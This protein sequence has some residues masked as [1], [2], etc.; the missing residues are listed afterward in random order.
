MARASSPEYSRFASPARALP[1]PR[2]LGL[3]FSAGSDSIAVSATPVG[4]GGTTQQPQ[5]RFLSPASPT[6]VTSPARVM[7]PSRPTPRLSVSPSR[8]TSPRLSASMTVPSSSLGSIA[9]QAGPPSTSQT[10]ENRPKAAVRGRPSSRLQGSA[11]NYSSRKSYDHKAAPS[12]AQASRMPFSVSPLQCGA[13]VVDAGGASCRAV[14]PTIVSRSV[15][16]PRSPITS[17]VAAPGLPNTTIGFPQAV[18]GPTFKSLPL[19]APR[20]DFNG[21]RRGGVRR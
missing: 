9:V 11:L 2:Q 7:S 5:P 12:V 13:F 8:P 14:S 16:P 19:A 17:F 1:S 6:R 18:I 3:A 10:S 20:W 15:S 4:T 21:V